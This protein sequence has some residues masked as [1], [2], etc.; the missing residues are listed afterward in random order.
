M[1]TAASVD[2]SDFDV[3]G[4]ELPWDY[5]ERCLRVLRDNR[6][7]ARILALTWGKQL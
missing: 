3:E 2:L 7:L 1:V 5:V 4:N 6:E